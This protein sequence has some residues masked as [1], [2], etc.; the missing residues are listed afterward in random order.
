MLLKL[1]E[2]MQDKSDNDIHNEIGTG[3]MF[4]EKYT[5]FLEKFDSSDYIKK[6]LKN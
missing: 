4:N 5:E 1:T 3:F 6:L 2:I